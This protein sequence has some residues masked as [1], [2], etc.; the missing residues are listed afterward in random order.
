M[1][2]DTCS[3]ATSSIS[4]FG[5]AIKPGTPVTITIRKT[6][7]TLG[8]KVS[9]GVRKGDI[10]GSFHLEGMSYPNA[11]YARDIEVAVVQPPIE[12]G[13]YINNVGVIFRITGEKM[14]RPSLVN[15]SSMARG[16]V[17]VLRTAFGREESYYK[18]IREGKTVRIADANGIPV[19][20]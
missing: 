19:S 17:Q 7:V 8:A 13:F 20:A 15:L 2:N 11:F 6:G 16:E 5:E 1:N 14:E 12:P 3:T 9:S 4:T 10:D 18:E